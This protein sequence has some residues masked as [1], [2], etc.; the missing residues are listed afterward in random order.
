MAYEQLEPKKLKSAAKASARHLFEMIDDPADRVGSQLVYTKKPRT[1]SQSFDGY[2]F[3]HIDGVNIINSNSTVDGTLESF[4]VDIEVHAWGSETSVDAV[5]QHDQIVD[6]IIYLLTGPEKADL[7]A[8]TGMTRP[9]IIRNVDFT[10]IEEKDQPVTRQEIEF[11]TTI[12]K[13]MA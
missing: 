11:R 1:K 8:Q 13:V 12:H 2:P 7:Q 3:I 4:T 6:Q 10:G 9:N 5:E